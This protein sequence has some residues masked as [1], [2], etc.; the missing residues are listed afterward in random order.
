MEIRSFALPAA[1]LVLLQMCCLPQG[2]SLAGPAPYRLTEMRVV[3]GVLGKVRQRYVDPSRL[4][5][6]KMLE[7]ALDAV[8]R[9]VPEVLVRKE[10]PGVYRIQ[11]DTEQRLFRLG[12][13]RSLWGLSSALE[14]IFRFISPHLHP[15]TDPKK[16]EF[17]AVD[18]ILSTLDPHTILL[19]PEYLKE[20]EV[21]TEGQFGGLGIE[22]S[23]CDGKL[24]VRRPLPNTPAW[25]TRMKYGPRGIFRIE[26]P[27]QAA[28]LVQR[29]GRWSYQPEPRESPALEVH[30]G[31]TVVR[32]RAGDR[33]VRI[34]DESTV[35]MTLSE[36]V[37]RLRGKPGTDVLIWIH[38][39]GWRRPRPFLIRRATI[40][41]PSVRFRWL[42]KPWLKKKIGYVAITRFSS[43]TAAQLRN[44]LEKAQGLEGLVIDLRGNHGGLLDQAASV[45][46]LFVASGTIVASKGSYKTQQI[47]A[48]RHTTLRPKLPL[49]VL[50]DQETA[51]AAE[52]VSAAFKQLNRAVVI[53]RR[54]FGKGS[55]Q[56]IFPLAYGTALKLT[57]SQW[58]APGN[59]SIQTSGLVPDVLC[60]PVTIRPGQPIV[61]YSQDFRFRKEKDLKAALSVP[62]VE[63][64]SKPYAVVRYL[65][66]PIPLEARALPCRYCGQPRHAPPRREPS[67]FV[68][69]FEVD[70][71]ARMLLRAGA[72]RR[73]VTLARGA[74]VIQEVRNRE[75]AAIQARLK[76]RT[77]DW[78]P[79]H[80]EPPVKLEA[81]FARPRLVVRAGQRLKITASVRNLGSRPVYRIWGRLETTSF[82]LRNSEFFFG[83]IEP[84][85]TKTATVAVWIPEGLAVQRDRLRLEVYAEPKSAL[86]SAWPKVVAQAHG[87]LDIRGLPRPEFEVT[88]RLQEAKDANHDGLL[89]P[90]E[91][92]EMPVVV[93]NTGTGPV[94]EGYVI[95][96]NKSGSALFVAS[97]RFSI[98]GLRP[99]ARKKVT[100]RFK[101]RRQPRDG[102][103][104]IVLRSYDCVL[105]RL[106][107]TPID[108][109]VAAVS[110]RLHRKRLAVETT[111]P[112][113]ARLCPRSFCP[114]IL[115]PPNATYRVRGQIGDW[116][117]LATAAGIAYVDRRQ[118]R[119]TTS[120]GRRLRAEVLIQTPRIHLGRV[121]LETHR[122]ELPLSLRADHPLGIADIYVT[123]SNPQAKIYDRKVAYR[124][125][126]VGK[127]RARIEWTTKVPL[128][129]GKNYI[130]I[131][132]RHND[133]VVASRLVVVLAT[134]SSRQP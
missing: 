108:L 43:S 91:W 70:L 92:V 10:G 74:S 55:V 114:E 33:I 59:L 78:R 107:E 22:I 87:T 29:R 41:V 62:T 72:P 67:A 5:P 8:Q 132:A 69:D 95:L 103:I 49:V 46:D 77:V 73:L 60:L 45:V 57:V 4:H 82:R 63:L 48:R 3:Y 121:P 111:R 20:L 9:Q 113:P 75:D 123:V 2:R 52:I 116:Y 30:R 127:R 130:R 115:L 28:R 61:Y 81:H 53:G 40:H 21:D 35:N 104:K 85:E 125:N 106:L 14:A 97:G 89:Q 93:R 134:P 7:E 128:W 96:Q 42:R 50:I 83:R 102:K 51:S 38:R 23:I 31:D 94:R 17:A 133:R 66:R 39:K 34:Q 26:P 65:K 19:R 129:K 13:I 98:T 84:G 90:G 99:G 6:A 122:L 54:T 15:D 117:A 27:G 47:R 120:R 11:V 44:I 109:W 16:V 37:K 64:K 124:S 36:S 126:P 71:A 80:T 112:T 68:W 25:K 88:Y 131:V 58:L 79:G 105:D 110:Q 101:V 100:F 76:T 119:Q 1:A 86:S 56:V 24:T 18:G 32:L 12:K 118:V